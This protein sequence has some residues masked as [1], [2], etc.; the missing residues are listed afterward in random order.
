MSEHGLGCL[1]A[2]SAEVDRVAVG[3]AESLA[4]VG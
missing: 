2:S 3:V 4:G 1:E